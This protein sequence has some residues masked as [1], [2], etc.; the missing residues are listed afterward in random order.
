MVRQQ[1]VAKAAGIDRSSV[2]RIL[3]NDPRALAFSE[4]TRERVRRIAAEMGYRHNL[5]AATVR[6]GFDNATVAIV[7]LGMFDDAAYHSP[8]IR[9]IQALN[10]AGFGTK[11]YTGTNLKN[12]FQEIQGSRIR[13][14]YLFASESADRA[15]AVEF[16][17]KHSL[18]LA[19][20]VSV[21]EFAGFPVFDNDNYRNMDTIVDYL[22]T[23]GHRSIALYCGPHRFFVQT[24]QRHQGFLDS[25]R[26]H[27]AELDAD[28][29]M[30][31]E[32]SEECLLDLLRRSE[33][34][35]LCCIY[36]T[37]ALRVIFT[38]TR[39]NIRVPEEIS[40]LSYGYYPE[41]RAS[42][43]SL[44]GLN[45][46]AMDIS[47]RMICYYRSKDTKNGEAFSFLSRGYM[48]PADSTAG[49]SVSGYLS[50]KKKLSKIKIKG[51]I[52]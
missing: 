40:V 22:W 41:N 47:D 11:L 1:D 21:Q 43:P 2:S 6:R 25:L 44:T 49:P 13:Y 34:T 45:D 33:P 5:P 39:W 28:W 46:H 35:A 10:N 4:E 50:L 27:G 38:L 9:V 16:C 30:C 12:I 14:V 17:S 7:M 8:T 37:L 3:N 29:V 48:V 52:T 51:E 23:L 42:I 36:P 31:E 18:K 24:N 32:F 20:R 26:T 19:L 15:Y